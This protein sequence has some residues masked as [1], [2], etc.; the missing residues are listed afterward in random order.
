MQIYQRIIGESSYLYKNV[1]QSKSKEREY[2]GSKDRYMESMEQFSIKII[3]SCSLN[4]R[5]KGGLQIKVRH[6]YKK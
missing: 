3:G 5:L 2:R 6:R 1:N 4:I